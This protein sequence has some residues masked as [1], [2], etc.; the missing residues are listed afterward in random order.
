MQPKKYL[1]I[2]DESDS[3][4]DSLIDSLNRYNLI[5]VI[6]FESMV[7]SDFVKWVQEKRETCHGILLDFVLNEKT[8]QQNQIA[9]YT[10][11]VAA[12]YLRTLATE[13]KIKDLPIILCSTDERL[14]RLYMNDLTS[15]DLFDM[16]FRKDNTD[17]YEIIAKELYSLA[18]GYEKMAVLKDFGKILDIDIS[19]LN[20]KIVAR[21]VNESS[22]PVHEIAQFVL[23]EMIFKVG[24]LIDESIL[25]ARLGVDIEKSKD[26]DN[27]KELFSSA[28]Y[29]G[30][31]SEGWD[32]W[33]MHQVNDI[34]K[35]F[36]CGSLSFLDADEKIE[37][38]K[39]KSKLQN[40]IAA[41]PLPYCSSKRFWTVNIN[42]K[43]P[44]DPSEGFRIVEHTEPKSWQEYNYLSPY[45]AIERI[46]IDRHKVHIIDQERLEYMKSSLDEA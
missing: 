9:E 41:E 25:A 21:F 3:K 5:Q 15:H 6:K 16:R 45:D 27:V 20:E 31:F 1:Y 38:L 12:Q 28:K 17:C 8:N 22:V 10:A 30:V 37:I 19:A 40:I 43:K 26:W 2:D 42:D 18:I 7:F 23:K 13:G 32:R 36:N 11:P 35:S 24:P 39:E 46:G 4:I 33:W 44:L 14:N 34:F 29:S